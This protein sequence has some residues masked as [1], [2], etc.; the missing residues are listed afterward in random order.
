[1]L[2]TYELTV[3]KLEELSTKLERIPGESKI[4]LPDKPNAYPNI[5]LA[6][7]ISNKLGVTFSVVNHYNKGNFSL[8]IAEFKSYLE[9]I[10]NQSNIYELLVVSGPNSR[11]IN[12]IN[13]LEYLKT[14]T[15]LDV[16]YPS[17]TVSV[18]YNCNS[19]DQ[20]VENNHLMKKLEYGVAN[21]VYIQITDD[22]EKIIT[23]INFIKTL[24][25]KL[26]ICVCI[27]EPTKLN[28]A[29][30]IFRPWKGVILCDDFLSNFQTA[31]KIN[32]QNMQVLQK[33]G[34]EYVITN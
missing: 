16:N 14:Q 5:L 25:S 11:K 33:F 21:K 6:K 12:V 29:K 31:N 22:V 3:S 32:K 8:I 23:G 28:L 10:K 34:V 7:N 19:T 26:V 13:I 17:L 27:F 1:M 24:N 4:H 2:L 20:V 18:S 9:I 15:N 30:F